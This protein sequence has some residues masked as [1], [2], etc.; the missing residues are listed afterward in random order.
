M[1]IARL[2]QLVLVIFFLVSCSQGAPRDAVVFI[3]EGASIRK[4]G[5]ILEEAGAVSATAFVIEARFWGSDEPIKP[6]EYRIKAGMTT[7]DLLALLQSGRTVQYFVTIPEGMPSVMVHDRLMAEKRLGGEVA[8]SE[9]GSVLPGTYAFTRGE[10]RAALLARMQS[11]MDKAFTRLWT[12]R[13]PRAAVNDRNQTI[14]LASIVEKETALAAE[15]RTVAGVYTNRLALG[16]KLQADPT[17]IY[18]ITRGRR[19][20]RR[21]R[22][23]EIKAVNDYNTYSMTGLPKGPITNPGKEAIAAVL[24]PQAHDYLFFVARGDGGHIFARTGAEHQKNV[25]DW[26]AIRRGRGEM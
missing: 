4:A 14:T 1:A 5:E 16:L 9:E 3:P 13:S 18:P 24:D 12:Q 17:I 19:L 11:A 26:Y 8:V 2:T 7:S 21:I 10:S 6:G 25:Q 23:S 15:R 20:G 22:K